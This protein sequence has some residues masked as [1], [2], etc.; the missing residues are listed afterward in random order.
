[1][2]L[3]LAINL[4]KEVKGHLFDLQGKVKDAKINWVH[5]KNLHLTLK[6]LGEVEEDKIEE[7]KK[8]I[9]IKEKNFRVSLTNLGFF[10][11]DKNPRIIWVGLEPEDKLIALEQKLDGELLTLFSE[12]SSQVFKAHITLGRI[13]SNRRKEDFHKSVQQV[14]VNKITFPITSFQLI[15]S[16]LRRGNLEYEV[17]ENVALS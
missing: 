12:N 17:H 8:R 10:P 5:K 11:S 13:K 2:R 16:V 14:N 1:M 4:P 6:F 7:L 15:N 9:Q 3:F